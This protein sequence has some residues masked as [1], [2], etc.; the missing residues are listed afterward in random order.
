MRRFLTDSGLAALPVLHTPKYVVEGNIIIAL[1]N[2]DETRLCVFLISI[3]LILIVD[4]SS[5]LQETLKSCCVSLS[6][7]YP[8]SR[9]AMLYVEQ[10][11]EGL[12][13]Q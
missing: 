4:I 3:H 9:I 7:S 13:V 12:V 5:C 8:Q 6:S 10:N 1:S 2:C 11:A